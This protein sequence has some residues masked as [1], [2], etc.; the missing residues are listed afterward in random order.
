MKDRHI[1]RDER[2]TVVENASFRLAYLVLTFGLLAVVAY[3]GLLWQESNWD[4]L[5]LVILGGLVT[6]FYQ[7]LHKVL[8]RQW[9]LTAIVAFV[10]GAAV[11]IALAMLR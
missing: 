7:G 3:R 11:A 6:T 10:V 4:L 5:A 2:T 8:S 1:M 9:A